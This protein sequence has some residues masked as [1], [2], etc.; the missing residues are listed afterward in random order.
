MKKDKIHLEFPLNKISNSM[1]WSLIATP[2][3]LLNWFADEIDNRDGVFT[4]CWS[5]SCLKADL[6]SSKEGV[7]VRYKW[8]DDDDDSSYFEFRISAVE[9]TGD[10]ALEITDFVDPDE[11]QEAIDLWRLQ[12]E[13]LRRALGM[14]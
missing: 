10:T 3:G 4:F 5:K 14:I 11:R 9:L 1:L 6:I 8:H 13:K 2:N 12:I 7:Y